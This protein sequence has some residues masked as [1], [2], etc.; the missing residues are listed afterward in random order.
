MTVFSQSG[1]SPE[2][3]AL[4]NAREYVKSLKK[5]DAL[6]REARQYGGHWSDRNWIT[7]NLKRS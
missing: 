6:Q 2:G 7:G 4:S 3:L 1:G 5:L